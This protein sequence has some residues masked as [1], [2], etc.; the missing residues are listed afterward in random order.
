MFTPA[1]AIALLT[2]LVSAASNRMA[3]AK[4]RAEL[5]PTEEGKRKAIDEGLL[6]SD[7]LHRM[8]ARVRAFVPE[9]KDDDKPA[10]PVAK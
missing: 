1:L 2:Q 8:I 10:A 5:E 4:M 9:L 6:F 3:L 7:T